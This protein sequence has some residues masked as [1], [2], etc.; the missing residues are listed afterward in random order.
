MKSQSEWKMQIKIARLKRKVNRR[1]KRIGNVI[2]SVCAGRHFF[3]LSLF[4]PTVCFA[5][6]PRVKIAGNGPTG[7]RLGRARRL[8]RK[9]GID[10]PGGVWELVRLVTNF[11]IAK[12]ARSA[13]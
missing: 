11:C 6:K 2:F 12:N 10:S 1:G 9:Y 7:K 8:G 13:P 3:N 5:E 4:L